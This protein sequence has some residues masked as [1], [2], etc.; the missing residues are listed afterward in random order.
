M[1]NKSYID[2]LT[3]F[4][5]GLLV[6]AIF[7]GTGLPWQEAASTWEERGTSNIINQ[8]VYSFVFLE[9]CFI[10]FRNKHNLIQLI[11]QEKFFSLFLIWCFLG[12]VWS[13]EEFMTFKAAFRLLTMHLAVISFLL[14]FNSVEELFRI[15]KPILLSYIIVNIL[16]VILVPAAI[17]PQFGS[18]RGI[19]DQ[20]NLLGQ[21]SV[22]SFVLCLI[23]AKNL[24]N[25]KLSRAIVT[26][27]S[28][29]A[30]VLVI[31]SRSTTA[32]ITVNIN[33]NYGWLHYF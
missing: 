31:G 1:L 24:N 16:T 33:F 29:F 19:M 8:V 26:I 9:S 15:I 14:H 22:V 20:K 10:L 25:K 18:W 30:I 21:Y 4:S 2:I 7:F 11:L 28:I 17:D 5:F 27:F 32:I 23:V 13:S 12:I 3:Y 6:T